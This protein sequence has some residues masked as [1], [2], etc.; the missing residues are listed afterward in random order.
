MPHHRQEAVPPGQP[1]YLLYAEPLCGLYRFRPKLFLSHRSRAESPHNLR[2]PAPPDR[3]PRCSRAAQIP[4]CAGGRTLPA[5]RRCAARCAGQSGREKLLRLQSG[6]R[7]SSAGAQTPSAGASA[8]STAKRRSGTAFC[9]CET[10]LPFQRLSY[11]AEPP[12]PAICNLGDAGTKIYEV[13]T[14]KIRLRTDFEH[15]TL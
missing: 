11:A 7:H 5:L 1:L 10:V 13:L 14:A 4:A 3:R 15:L 8:L 2:Q 12:S 9:L 6:D